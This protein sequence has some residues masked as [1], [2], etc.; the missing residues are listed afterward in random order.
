V[1]G[2]GF[3]SYVIL[4]HNQFEITAYLFKRPAT[5]ELWT[6]LNLNPAQFPGGA[7]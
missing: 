3:A 6:M 5:L 7:K 1:N 4:S 2:R